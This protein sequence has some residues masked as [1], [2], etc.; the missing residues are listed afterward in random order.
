MKIINNIIIIC[1]IGL[2]STTYLF[3]LSPINYKDTIEIETPT[4]TSTLKLEVD[5]TNFTNPE[6]IIVKHIAE[7][8]EVTKSVSNNVFTANIYQQDTLVSSNITDLELLSPSSDMNISINENNPM[9]TTLDISQ[10]KLKLDDGTYKIVLQSNLISNPENSKVT[11]NVT[12]DT[13][14]T[15]YSALNSAP[16]GTK[17]LTLYFAS[18]NIDT[19]I[20]V[21]RF[22]VEDKSITRMAI[23]QLQNGPLSNNMK[24]L[25][26]DVVNTTY[27][28]GN[29]VIDLPS[30]YEEYNNSNYGQKSHQSFVKSIFAVDRYWPIYSVK[31]TVDRKNVETYFNNVDTKNPIQNIENYCIY[32]AYR[33]DDRY[34]LFDYNVDTNLTGITN[35]DSAEIIAQKL[36]DL[37]FDLELNFG[38]NPIPEN[39][40]LKGVSVEGNYL[41]LDFNEAFK[42]AY[43][44]KDDLRMM[45]IES[46]VYT[47]TT[48]PNIDGLLITVDNEPLNNYVKNVDLTGILY[49]PEFINPEVIQ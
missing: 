3:N 42:K 45:M 30:S 14:G 10:K 40:I 26:G 8:D 31:F 5:S 47:F 38:R 2:L 4:E 19:L 9:I 24:T 23:E 25:I 44:N 32:L 33:I 39:I 21:T 17:G 49:P 27:N 46:L 43:E 48:I 13:S 29:V 28:N 20:P 18:E 7:K 16:A 36:Y 6:S 34:F 1:L 11:I 12:Y 15:Y 41:K 35:N 22:V 37:Y